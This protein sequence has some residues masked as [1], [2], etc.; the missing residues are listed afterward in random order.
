MHTVK[1][2]LRKPRRVFTFRCDDPAIMRGQQ[3][4]VKSDRGLE[5]GACVLP[6]EPCP[7]EMERRYTMRV[8]RTADEN[9]ER[10]EQ[11]LLAEE[12]R[13]H[14]LCQEMIAKHNMPMKL[15]DVEFTFDKHKI[16]FYFTADDRVDFR[17]LVRDLAHSLRARIEM[18]HIQ[19][20]D[21]AKMVGGLGSCGRELCCTTWIGEF[22]PISMRMAKRQNLS[23]N[24]TKISGQCGRLLCCLSYENDQ[25]ERAREKPR[26]SE[27]GGEPEARG[28][29]EAPKR[30]A[31][32]TAADTAAEAPRQPEPREAAPA[33]SPA[34]PGEKPAQNAADRS[35][36]PKKRRRRGGKGRGG[37]GKEPKN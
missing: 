14:A 12:Q 24:P 1:V 21:E 7:K 31:P 36:R 17:E 29:R 34:P 5:L 19:V 11:H 30:K 8:I 35:P 4:V 32:D 9:D 25:Y 10:T 23:L 20:R 26:K 33:A 13:A 28:R 22:K 6:P 27:G 37:K 16:V 2:R 15:V 18:R 3:C